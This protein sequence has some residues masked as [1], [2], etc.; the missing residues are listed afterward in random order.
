MSKDRLTTEFINTVIDSSLDKE[1]K[2]ALLGSIYWATDDEFIKGYA[3]GKL[4]V[5]S[6]WSAL[7]ILAFLSQLKFIPREILLQMIDKK[8]KDFKLDGATS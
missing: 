3:H 6:G 2:G 8:S 1:T 5:L 7:G 4:K